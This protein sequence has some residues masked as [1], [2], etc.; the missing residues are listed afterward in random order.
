[1]MQVVS[2]QT[3]VRCEYRVRFKQTRG[4]VALF[5]RPT[6]SFGWTGHAL[7]RIGPLGVHIAAARR[8]FGLTR[9]EN[10]FVAAR[11]IRDVYRQAESVRLEFDDDE[12]RGAY[13]RFW[14]EDCA[15]AASIVGELPTSHT[16]E[17]DS[18][19][20][21]ATEPLA[22]LER[23]RKVGLICLALVCLIAGVWL[24]VRLATPFV[25][26]LHA[27]NEP[28]AP[29]PGSPL[30][31]RHPTPFTAAELRVLENDFRSFATT[32]E[33]LK[34]DFTE[35]LFALQKREIEPYT[36][37]RR[38]EKELIP[39]WQSEAARLEVERFEPG[40]AR[41]RLQGLMVSIARHWQQALE[42][43]VRGL[44]ADDAGIVNDAFA[45]MAQAEQAERDV[46]ELI[47]WAAL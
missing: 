43:Y 10:R 8:R 44:Q 12:R 29:Q 36:F 21:V 4:L 9:H 16:V 46:L 19:A 45:S 7:L 39:R 38:L 24:I 26:A 41:V 1:M 20:E 2:L 18:T 40:S 28:L 6:N 11:Q 27:L 14:A 33:S 37:S 32:S 34:R 35:F 5:E 23:Y 31:E 30:A 3:T 17:S 25:P 42:T 22:A 15:A 13:L 47:R